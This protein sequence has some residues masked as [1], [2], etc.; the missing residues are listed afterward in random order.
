MLNALRTRAS[1][2][3]VKVLVTLLILAFALWSVTDFL[4]QA[5]TAERPVATVGGEEIGPME[6]RSRVNSLIAS[7]TRQSGIAIDAEQA[8]QFG[9]TQAAL[10]EL[11]GNRLYSVFGARQGIEVSPDLVNARIAGAGQFRNEQGQFDPDRFAAFL[12][13]VDVS[14][15]QF[16]EEIRIG[17]VKS[18]LLG[19]I[20]SGILAP[21]IL[22][23]RLYAFR[24]QERVARTLLIPDSSIAETFTPD[25]TA[26]AEFHKTNGANYQAPEYRGVTVVRL[27][28]EALIAQF[29]VGDEEIARTYEAEKAKYVIP[30]RRDIELVVYPDEAAAKA[31]FDLLK[32]G[33]ALSDVATSGGRPLEAHRGVTLADL[34][35]AVG[36][37]VAKAAFA[38]A[39]GSVTDP[40]LADNGWA[41]AQI[42]K[43]EP[44]RQQTLE[45][46]KA[47]IGR[48]LALLRAQ[49]E[50]FEIAE[51][52][53]DQR[54]GG[55]TLEDA[56]AALQLP[57][58][59]VAAVDSA[60]K[61]AA[62]AP[63][64]GI[65]GDAALLAAVF[66]TDEG[67]ES[68]LEESA[69]GGFF[70]LRVDAIVPAATKPLD[71]VRDKAIA[72]WQASKR[73]EA[74][75][76]KAQELA[77]RIQAG[78]TLDKIAAE[79][80]VAV[81]TSDPFT[82]RDAE[83]GADLS[84][85]LVAKAFELKVGDVATARAGGDGGELLLVL[86]EIRPVDLGKRAVEIVD[87]RE[88]LKQGI[89]DDVSAQLADVLREEIGVEIDQ[90]A[91]DALF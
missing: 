75:A 67:Q 56:A 68:R 54:G 88:D 44:G 46:V 66:A 34:T 83:P 26:L 79:L 60:G 17:T 39:Q 70:A 16:A 18:F 58:T 47:A 82:R 51:Q 77:Q 35:T 86:A 69:G 80:G 36:E 22:A 4:Q 32:Q 50:I 29:P 11:I 84:P 42:A 24:N 64:A 76:A 31:A 21:K 7:L 73:R 89:A 78:E 5:G 33:R 41:L 57:V 6:L 81:Q 59:K 72:D 62:G 55:L 15:A 3:P 2:W 91:V 49:D 28:P 48:E 74:A 12:R 63:V 85:A 20:G 23:E 45:E 71:Q 14:E 53:E 13:N 43:V 90:A 19:S 27:D 1:S 61:D 9:L 38:A 87:L 25:D 52:F 37:P 40:L 8:R 65:A 10:D 30:E